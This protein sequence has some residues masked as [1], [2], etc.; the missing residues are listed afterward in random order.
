VQSTKQITLAFHTCRHTTAAALRASQPPAGFAL[1]LKVYFR[2]I[3]VN[4]FKGLSKLYAD[5][6]IS[7]KFSA[8][9]IYIYFS[10]TK[11]SN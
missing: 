11:H 1:A 10:T 8:L 2:L 3:T 6:L 9:L 4:C 7:K 5:L